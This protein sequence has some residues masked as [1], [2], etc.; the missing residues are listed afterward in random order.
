MAATNP[1]NDKQYDLR[2][3]PK[4][5]FTFIDVDY[6]AGSKLVKSVFD[7]AVCVK[8]CP[9]TK[10]DGIQCSPEMMKDVTYKKYCT[11]PEAEIWPSSSWMGYCKVFTDG[12][13]PKAKK[14][15]VFVF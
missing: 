7:M 9:A 6:Y 5:Y 2:Q 4:L 13:P 10:A 8:K 15:W 12:I 1:L 14:N 3:Y 11:K